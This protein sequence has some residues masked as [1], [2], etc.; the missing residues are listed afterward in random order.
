MRLLA[1][2]MLL[3]LFPTT[4][5][6]PPR[7]ERAAPLAHSPNIIATSWVIMD[8]DIDRD[9]KVGVRNSEGPN[10]FRDMA[11]TSVRQWTFAPARTKEPVE[12]R[13]TAVFLFRP[14]DLFSGTAPQLPKPS[15]S[16]ADRPPRA[17]RLSDPGYPKTSV[18]EG[19]VVLELRISPVG[20]VE[21]VR[22]VTGIAGLTE[23]TAKVVRPWGFAPAL[24]KGTAVPGTVVAVVSYLRAVTNIPATGN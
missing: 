6:D 10:P 23:P 9:G 14:R 1:S 5:F 8:L 20:N 4:E 7:L 3:Y 21:N 2:L 24:R 12:S 17:L 18:G 19:T 16:D 15:R 11:L 13:V 22:V